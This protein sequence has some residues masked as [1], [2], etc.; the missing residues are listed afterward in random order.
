MYEQPFSRTL[1][2]IFGSMWFFVNT[3]QR[4]WQ[5]QVHFSIMEELREIRRLQQKKLE[6]AKEMK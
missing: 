6:G 1:F 5:N 2:Y 3:G 4:A